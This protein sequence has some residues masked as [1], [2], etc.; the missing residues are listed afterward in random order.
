MG[1]QIKKKNVLNYG[2]LESSLLMGSLTLVGY[3]LVAVVLFI[4]FFGTS[5]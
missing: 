2:S 1:T 4:I 3:I 5:E